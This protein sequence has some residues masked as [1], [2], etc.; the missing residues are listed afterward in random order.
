MQIFGID[1]DFKSLLQNFLDYSPFVLAALCFIMTILLYKRI[2]TTGT[3]MLVIA[4]FLFIISGVVSQ[5]N[6]KY[7]DELSLG[8]YIM[9]TFLIFMTTRETSSFS[10]GLLLTVFAI[11]ALSL[12]NKSYKYFF[13]NSNNSKPMSFVVIPSEKESKDSIDSKVSKVSTVS[14]PTHISKPQPKLTKE[15]DTVEPSIYNIYEEQQYKQ[16]PPK[17]FRGVKPRT[18]S[19][20][21]SSTST[22]SG[23]SLG[24]S[25]SRAGSSFDFG[26]GVQPKRFAPKS[27][28]SIESVTTDTSTGDLKSVGMIRTVQTPRVSGVSLSGISF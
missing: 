7:S 10:R 27:V 12:I 28:E 25:N 24:L 16:V 26:S 14:I 21:G 20:S 2:S 9:A 13:H 22:Y 3:V 1:I 19:Y 23:S 15:I 6:F 18:S 8:S 11:S 17:S 4:G 5:L